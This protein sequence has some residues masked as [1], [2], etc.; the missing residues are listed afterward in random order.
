M[1]SCN[2][3]MARSISV[4]GS[5]KKLRR[6]SSVG[7][8]YREGV[9]YTSGLLRLVWIFLPY[10]DAHHPGDLMK[11]ITILLLLA[12]FPTAFGQLPADSQQFIRVDAPV[13]ALTHVR[14]IDGTGAEPLE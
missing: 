2:R 10:F 9:P 13:V 5:R 11:I 7:S 1:R 12:V 3:R 4:V 8:T 6:L 14:I